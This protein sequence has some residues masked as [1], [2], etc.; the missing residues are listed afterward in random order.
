MEPGTR[1]LADGTE[2]SGPGRRKP[3][4]P[5]SLSESCF[6]RPEALAPREA[7]SGSE[8]RGSITLAW[9]SCLEGREQEGQE[10]QQLQG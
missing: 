9:G 7:A 8:D 1:A 3:G 4:G 10:G 2:A 5:L 6:L